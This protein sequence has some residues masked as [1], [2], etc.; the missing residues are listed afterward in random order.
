MARSIAWRRAQVDAAASPDERMVAAERLLRA[1][2]A[3]RDPGLADIAFEAAMTE[4]LTVVDIVLASPTLERVDLLGMRHLPAHLEDPRRPG[5]LQPDELRL[6]RRSWA[7]S[8]TR[9]QM[10]EEAWER[11]T[12]CALCGCQFEFGEPPYITVDHIVPLAR[13]GTN[14]DVNLQILCEPCNGRKGAKF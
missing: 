9:D 7:K 14:A 10:Y 4:I 1:V 8:K 2:L 3:D 12:P 6:R 13:G 5:W 11:G